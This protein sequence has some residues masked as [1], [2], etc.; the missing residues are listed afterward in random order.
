MCRLFQ[1][2]W[3]LA[4]TG[5]Y[6]A[7]GELVQVGSSSN[8]GPCAAAVGLLRAAEKRTQSDHCAEIYAKVQQCDVSKHNWKREA[9][10]GEGGDVPLHYTV[11]VLKRA[12]RL[13]RISPA[14]KH[15][16]TTLFCNL[17]T[18]PTIESTRRLR[19]CWLETRLV[20]KIN[21]GTRN[22]WDRVGSCWKE[23]IRT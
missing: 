1:A 23:P 22:E 20:T 14:L 18:V 4:S 10:S 3:S 6:L 12:R 5:Q 19:A 17:C 8:S 2:P 7:S 13:H 11:P 9:C 21:S 15:A 16:T